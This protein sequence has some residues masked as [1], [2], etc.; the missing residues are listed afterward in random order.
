MQRLLEGQRRLETR[1][2]RLVDDMREVK[3]RLTLLGGQY[4][5]LS[6]RTNRIEERLERIETRFG[7]IDPALPNG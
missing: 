4:A 3:E 2:D 7:L 6:R 1:M 5:S